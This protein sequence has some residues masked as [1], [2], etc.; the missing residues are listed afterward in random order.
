MQN[1]HISGRRWF[2]RTYGNT[3][4]SARAWIDGEPAA[5]IDFAYGYGD[6]YKD[7]MLTALECNDKIPPR[8]ED[9]HG[10]KE[11]WWEYSDR[12]G[13]KIITDV[14]D[15]TRQKDLHSLTGR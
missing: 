15:V 8:L 4:F 7:E 10:R 11:A 2:Q 9:Q 5:L 1:I 6:H 12:T 13:I 14:S 3:Y